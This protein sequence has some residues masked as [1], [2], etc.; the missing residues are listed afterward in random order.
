MGRLKLPGREV[1]HTGRGYK[2]KS[3]WTRLSRRVVYEQ[4]CVCSRISVLDLGWRLSEC[5]RGGMEERERGE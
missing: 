4:A 2:L 1:K 5:E 3:S